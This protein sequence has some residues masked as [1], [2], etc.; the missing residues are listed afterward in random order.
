[1]LH[2]TDVHFL[3]GAVTVLLVIAIAIGLFRA[4]HKMKKVVFYEFSDAEY[5]LEFLQKGDSCE[6]ADWMADRRGPFGPNRLEDSF[7]SDLGSR[8]RGINWWDS[9]LK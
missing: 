3:A 9:D 8:A 4:N 2:L 6:A 1:M 7:I 5:D